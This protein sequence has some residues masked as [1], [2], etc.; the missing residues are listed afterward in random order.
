MAELLCI[1]QIWKNNN[2]SN[3]KIKIL[4][5]SNYTIKLERVET[6]KDED[7]LT[8]H[9]LAGEWLNMKKEILQQHY[10][11][12]KLEVKVFYGDTCIKCK[13]WYPYAIKQSDFSCWG[14]ENGY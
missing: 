5:V 12:C 7:G 4:S 10:T 14:C 6:C 8:I 11:L 2:Y 1:G 3:Y 13:R 9:P